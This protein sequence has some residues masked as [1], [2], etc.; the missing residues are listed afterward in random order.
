MSEPRG[1]VLTFVWQTIEQAARHQ[2][3]EQAA[4][5]TA[6]LGNIPDLQ[7]YLNVVAL[8]VQAFEPESIPEGL[9]VTP[10]IRYLLT[11]ATS[12]PA[13]V[14]TGPASKTLERFR[15]LPPMQQLLIVLIILAVLWAAVP[16][17]RDWVSGLLGEMSAAVAILLAV[18]TSRSRPGRR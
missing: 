18:N 4:E 6:A 12:P 13:P 15:A 14:A 5:T 11:G 1:D 10:V 2:T 9:D 3:P 8:V 17:I 16:E 7:P